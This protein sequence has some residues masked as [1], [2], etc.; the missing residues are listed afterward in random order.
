MAGIIRGKRKKAKYSLGTRVKSKF[1]SGLENEELNLVKKIQHLFYY[2][3]KKNSS[4]LRLWTK[5]QK[6]IA[7]TL[8]KTLKFYNFQMMKTA[9]LLK[10]H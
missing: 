3:S 6:N 7:G 9:L 2:K 10:V 5:E 1:K 8:A 4:N